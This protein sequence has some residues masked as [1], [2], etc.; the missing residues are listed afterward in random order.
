[1]DEIFDEIAGMESCLKSAEELLGARLTV[2]DRHGSLHDGAGRPL[3]PGLRQSHRKSA[4]CAI[5]FCHRCIERC[6]HWALAN[7]ERTGDAFFINRCWKGLMEMVAPI[8]L[9]GGH[10]AGLL[11]AGT[12]R[13]PGRRTPRNMKLLPQ[14]MKE[15]YLRLEEFDMERA[16]QLGETLS[17]LAAGLASRLESIRGG[18]GI[19]SGDRRTLIREYIF[20]NA[21]KGASLKILGSRLGISPSR[22]GHAVRELFGRGIEALVMEERLNRAKNLLASTSLRI[23]EISA[24]AGFPDQF[25][26]SRVF[27]RSCGVPPKGFRERLMKNAASHKR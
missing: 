5:G 7:A 16:R 19:E 22:A 24:L 6:R 26:F 20:E 21:G 2:I 3:F 14:A 10:C 9:K 15:E 4:T 11:Y 25:S 23:G 27:K 13:E 17:L 8:R 1:M 18:S 12:W